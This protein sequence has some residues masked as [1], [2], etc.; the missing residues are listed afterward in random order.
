MMIILRSYRC[1]S[2]QGE[3]AT[4]AEVRRGILEIDNLHFDDKL[5]WQVCQGHPLLDSNPELVCCDV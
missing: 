5:L 1:L 2:D 4:N 3:C